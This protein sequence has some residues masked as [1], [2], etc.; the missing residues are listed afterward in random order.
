MNCQ[1][2]IGITLQGINISHLRKRKIIFKSAFLGGYVSSLE[3]IYYTHGSHL[4]FVLPKEGLFPIKTRDIWVP[5]TRVYVLEG[6]SPCTCA[7]CG[8]GVLYELPFCQISVDHPPLGSTFPPQTDASATSNVP[9][10]ATSRHQWHER[11]SRRKSKNWHPMK[12][13]FSAHS[14][15]QSANG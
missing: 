15:H 13:Q 10:S 8:G 5:D 11:L 14:W 12:K 1:K 3:G 9:S 2:V 7:F 4:S 6:Q